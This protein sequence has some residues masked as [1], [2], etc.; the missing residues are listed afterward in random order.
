MRFVSPSSIAIA[1]LAGVALSAPGTFQGRLL[2][3]EPKEDAADA[4][5]AST[6]DSPATPAARDEAIEQ[7]VRKQLRRLDANQLADRVAAEKALIELGPAALDF[8]PEIT[9]AT[10]AEIKER[11]SRVRSVLEKLAVARFVEPS[12]VTLSGTMTVEEAALE[13]RKQTGNT[14]RDL[15]ESA[16]RQVTVDWKE[17]PFWVAFDD[18]TEQANLGINPFGGYEGELSLQAL[19]ETGD[20]APIRAYAGIFRVQATRVQSVRNLLVPGA[21]N[22]RTTIQ[23]AWEPRVKPISVSLPLDRMSATSEDGEELK[24]SREGVLGAP[25]LSGVSTIDL[26]VPMELPPRSVESIATLRGE[27]IATLPGRVEQ[28]EFEDLGA[29]R[30]VE[31]TRAGVKVV[32]E[33]VR[34]NQEL[35]EVRVRVEFDEA[36]GALESHQGWIYENEVWVETADGRKLEPLSFAATRQDTN[37]VG[38]AYLFDLEKGPKGAKF[39]YRTPASIV[40]RELPFELKNIPLP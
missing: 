26:D 31:K 23:I 6:G 21:D 18:L 12:P 27:L 17:T 1:L 25:A 37:L 20:L 28:F 22:L 32:L 35:H 24:F 19:Q 33:Q 3:Q 4:P 15:G 38:L 34:K 36:S 2:A 7:E 11:L 5:Q 10:S 9:P 30:A 8:L 13:L 16:T 39:F 14:L 40:K 29:A